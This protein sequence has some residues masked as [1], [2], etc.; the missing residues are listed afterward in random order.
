MNPRRSS[1]R[2]MISL[3]VAGLTVRVPEVCDEPAS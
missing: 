1:A 3:A 2:K